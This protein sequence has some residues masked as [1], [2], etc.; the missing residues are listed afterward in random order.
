MV[1]K[2]CKNV[3]AQI[4]AQLQFYCKIFFYSEN[5]LGYNIHQ[6]MAKID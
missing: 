2:N 5:I 4:E 6:S 1:T 3:I